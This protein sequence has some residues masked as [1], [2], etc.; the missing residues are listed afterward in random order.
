VVK[1]FSQ[2]NLAYLGINVLPNQD[3]YVMPFMKKTKYSFTPLKSTNDWAEKYY[4]VK[5]Q[6]TNFL[7]DKEGNIVFA[8]FRTNQE[9]ERTLELMIDS[10]INQ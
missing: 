6:P 9:N 10:L 1:K 4:N 5:G 3:D 7:L 2:K 8:Y